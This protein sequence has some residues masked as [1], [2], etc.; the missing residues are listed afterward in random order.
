LIFVYGV[1]E[2]G[3]FG[4]EYL[5]ARWSSWAVDNSVDNEDN[6]E[7]GEFGSLTKRTY[8]YDY[9]A[10]LLGGISLGKPF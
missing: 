7:F 10:S 6:L 4:T 8:R 1:W 9:H 2:F 5:G 3:E